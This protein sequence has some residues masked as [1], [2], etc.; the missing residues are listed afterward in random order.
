MTESYTADYTRS[1]LLYTL[2]EWNI[3]KPN[4]AA[5]ITDNGAN[6]VKAI[7]DGYGRE[8]HIPCFA[9]TINLVVEHSIS[10]I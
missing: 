3:S 2:N 4:I 6:M 7:Y 5:V 8:N 10:K 9:N 1:Q